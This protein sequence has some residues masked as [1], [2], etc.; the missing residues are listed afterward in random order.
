MERAATDS[1]SVIM[2]FV[3]PVLTKMTFVVRL[4]DGD[5]IEACEPVTHSMIAYN[6][7]RRDVR[8]FRIASSSSHNTLYTSVQFVQPSAIIC[9]IVGAINARW[10][11]AAVNLVRNHK[12][13]RLLSLPRLALQTGTQCCIYAGPH[14]TRYETDHNC[15]SSML[16]HMQTHQNVF[17]RN[18]EMTISLKCQ[19]QQA[20]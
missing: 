11:S 4:E 16:K 1:F 15:H 10:L 7:L 6:L 20:M 14:V 3:L 13:V 17:I 19:F 8:D 5:N 12:I 18:A 2:E 9:T